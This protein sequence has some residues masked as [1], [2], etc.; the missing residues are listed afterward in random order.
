MAQCIGHCQSFI[1]NFP[2]PDTM[3]HLKF[4][5][6]SATAYGS[7]FNS[8]AA[9]IISEVLYN[10]PGSDPQGEWIE[11]FNNGASLVILDGWSIGDEE[12]EGATSGTESMYFFPTG[13]TISPGEIQIVSMGAN[14]FLT[15]YGFLPT[16]ELVSADDNPD[17]PN[18]MLNSSWDP[19]GGIINLSNSNDQV[20]LLDSNNVLIDAVSWNSTF[21]FD[22]ALDS[23]AEGDG[24]SY[25]RIDPRTDTDTAADWAL[26]TGAA[27][28]S[29]GSIPEPSSG[30]LILASGLLMLKRR[31]VA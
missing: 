9:V 8:Q 14:Q 1:F 30:I 13:A 25:F 10:E 24:Q 19:D 26:S 7:C 2:I 28:S 16:Y 20:L 31:R 6:F 15:L 3:N 22:P 12:T 23:N 5:I 17:V 21:A 11:I 27:L 18:L 29:P 4:A